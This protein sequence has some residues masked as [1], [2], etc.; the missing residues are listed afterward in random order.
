MK[1]F[2]IDRI[3]NDRAVLECE[4]GSI[5]SVELSSLPKNIREGDI[6]RFDENSCFLSEAETQRRKKKIKQLMDKL[7]EE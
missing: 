4:N 5:V 7:F 2:T 1:K 3:E 6:L